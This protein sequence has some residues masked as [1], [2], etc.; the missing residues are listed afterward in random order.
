MCQ[1]TGRRGKRG[2]GPSPDGQPPHQ[3]WA[4][5]SRAA[6]D[7]S[8]PAG[9]PPFPLQPQQQGAAPGEAPPVMPKITEDQSDAQKLPEDEVMTESEVAARGDV[10]MEQGASEQLGEA[11]GQPA[12]GIAES[13]RAPSFSPFSVA[14]P[15]G[16]S[17]SDSDTESDE[18][19]DKQVG[20][21]AHPLARIHTEAL[22]CEED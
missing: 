16:E 19:R 3:R 13:G 14:P 20:L 6:S 5:L 4:A 12:I 15:A 21:A 8:S 17:T 9:Q 2:G 22:I 10:T 1:V 18:S 7:G 11:S